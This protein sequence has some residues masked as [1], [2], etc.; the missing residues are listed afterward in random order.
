MLAAFST[1]S[2]SPGG[3]VPLADAKNYLG[4]YGTTS[5]DVLIQGIIEAATSHVSN[6]L[7]EPIAVTEI[8]DYFPSLASRLELTHEPIVTHDPHPEN[9]L[10]GAWNIY[11]GGSHVDRTSLRYAVVLGDFIQVEFDNVTNPV[12]IV[13]DTQSEIARLHSD[14]LK[15]TILLAVRVLY[16]ERSV[17]LDPRLMAMIFRRLDHVR[18][19]NANVTSNGFSA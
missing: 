11:P 2:P 5:E 9:L 10:G 15:F 18:R 7:E 17:E 1:T 4:V 14:L 6:H 8:V 19:R 12:R 13:Y 3:F 16:D